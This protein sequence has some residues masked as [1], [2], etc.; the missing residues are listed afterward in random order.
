ML[1]PIQVSSTK[2]DASLHYFYQMERVYQAHDELRLYGRPGIAVNSYRGQM[3]TTRHSLHLYWTDRFYNVAV[4]W[5]SDWKPLSHY[6]NV[7]TPAT[8]VDGTLRFIDLDLD[9]IWSAVTGEVILDDEDEFEAHRVRF[10]YPDELV[11]RCWQ[12]SR[13]LHD[14]IARGVYPFDGSLYAWRPYGAS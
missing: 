13:E 9:V 5:S 4:N 7:A 6:V 3:L 12:T 10:G 14:L 11:E 8:W 1:Q 2:Y